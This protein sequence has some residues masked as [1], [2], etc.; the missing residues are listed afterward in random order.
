[1]R[2]WSVVVTGILAG[3]AVALGG[4]VSEQQIAADAVWVVQLDVPAFMQSQLG[5]FVQQEAQKEHAQQKLAWLKET[6]GLDPMKDIDAATLYGKTFQHGKGVALVRGRFSGDKLVGLLSAN[7]THDKAVYG[8]SVI[9]TW[10]DEHSGKPCAG[11]IYAPD[12]LIMASSAD[13]L[14][15][16]IDVLEGRAAGLRSGFVPAAPA[17]M[18]VVAAA[19]DQTGALGATPQAKMLQNAKRVTFMA[20]ES[21][22]NAQVTLCLTGKT[23]AD[24]VNMEQVIQGMLA[25]ATLAKD[26]NPQAAELAGAV[27]VTRQGQDVNAA[28]SY[29]AAKLIAQMQACKAQHQQMRQCHPSA[30]A[31]APAP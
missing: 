28:M 18:I 11:C 10:T 31:S 12:L 14:K 24:A 16:A 19:E 5:A 17:G 3:A 7:A 27:R 9:H 23:E 4:A 25:L 13:D 6:C 26:K 30:P 15:A 21:A 29:P 20:G 1:M 2:K 8:N 22:G